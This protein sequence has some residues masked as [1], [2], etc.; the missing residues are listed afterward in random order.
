MN[1]LSHEF[2]EQFKNKQFINNSIPY[3][4]KKS[5]IKGHNGLYN[6]LSSQACCINFFYPFI[7]EKQKESLK[8]LLF[9]LGIEVDSVITIKPNSKFYDENAYRQTN[10]FVTTETSEDDR[11]IKYPD[12][13][14]VLFEW[15]GPYKSPTGENSGYL[16]GHHRTSIDAYILAYIKGKVT[17]L[18]IEWKFTESYSSR[19]N[20]GK[21]LGA[22]GIERLAR[23]APILARD[24]A[25]GKE[26]L[27]KIDDIDYW[28]LYDI[29][30]E[31][32][33]QLLRQHMLG[34]ETVGMCFGDYYIQDYKVI[35][36]TH[37][38]NKKLNV[39]TDKQAE[40]SKGFS[41]FVGNQIHEI[42][43]DLLNTNFKEKFIGAYWDEAVLKFK[44][45]NELKSW[46]DYIVERYCKQTMKN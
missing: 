10:L 8:Q 44:P 23:Y 41:D 46:Y 21:F 14:N 30:Y 31:P 45:N 9:A 22:K 20:T 37:S 17:Q 24:R 19:Q 29:C 25:L 2:Q 7:E 32:F 16:R 6:P 36:L 35:H 11:I 5:G 13:G 33:Y 18:L 1:V 40:Y 28:G 42:W 15:I 34:Q 38:A 3:M 39:L 43:S 4:L 12:G 27:F 26:I